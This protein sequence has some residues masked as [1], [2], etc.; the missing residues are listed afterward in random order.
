MFIKLHSLDQMLKYNFQLAYG[1]VKS[2]S[3]PYN[4]LVTGSSPSRVTYGQF[5]T[6]VN[7]DENTNFNFWK[8]EIILKRYFCIKCKK[9]QDI[10]K[11]YS[12]ELLI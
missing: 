2:G 7:G 12:Q 10:K 8:Q 4:N 11:N 3:A 9:E 5:R 1:E 6:L